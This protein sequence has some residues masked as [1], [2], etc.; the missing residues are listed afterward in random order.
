MVLRQ[1]CVLGSFYLVENRFIRGI[2]QNF[3]GISQVLN[4]NIVVKK[5]FVIVGSRLIGL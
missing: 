1:K 5:V 2:F 4:D 3:Q